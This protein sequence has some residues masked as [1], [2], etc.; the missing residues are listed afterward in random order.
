MLTG[1]K[2]WFKGLFAKKTVAVEE[3]IEEKVVEAAGWEKYHQMMSTVSTG[4]EANLGKTIL[5]QEQVND[6]I[7]DSVTQTAPKPKKKAS[8]KAD[9]M[10]A[11][12]PAKT[13][14]TKSPKN[15]K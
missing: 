11:D 10:K 3:K 15:S 7:T 1:I 12:K 5:K 8:K 6:Q 13:P 4:L 2:K 9:T 14:K